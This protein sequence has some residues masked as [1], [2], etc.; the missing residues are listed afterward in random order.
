MSKNIEQQ[1]VDI[2]KKAKIRLTA[3]RLSILKVLLSADAPLTQ[4]NIAEKLG[5]DSPDKVTIY[6]TL[7]TFIEANVVHKAFLKHRT[8][9]YEL[10]HHCSEHQCHPH[11]TCTK[12]GQTHCLTQINV[13]LAPKTYKGFLIQHQQV[14]F[15]GICPTCAN[16]NRS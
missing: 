7:E 12:C 4:E 8:W 16:S 14:R 15:D 5:K 10:A 6:R 3:P 1:T 9:H 2:L 11:F 13:P